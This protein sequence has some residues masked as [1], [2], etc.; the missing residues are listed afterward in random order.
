MNT[1]QSTEQ[2][3][4]AKNHQAPW[5]KLWLLNWNYMHWLMTSVI[6]TILCS[7]A[8]SLLLSI[9][10]EFL[11]SFWFNLGVSSSFIASSLA[12]TTVLFVGLLTGWLIYSAHLAFYAFKTANHDYQP[13]LE[14]WENHTPN[15]SELIDKLL[16]DQNFYDLSKF[17]QQQN[18]PQPIKAFL[19]N[20]Q[21]IQQIGQ[22]M[23]L[24]KRIWQIEKLDDKIKALSINILSEFSNSEHSKEHL[25]NIWNLCDMLLKKNQFT[26]DNVLKSLENS[27]QLKTYLPTLSKLY[28]HKDLLHKIIEEPKLMDYILA[29][30]E[31]FPGDDERI[32]YNIE[33]LYLYMVNRFDEV[34]VYEHY[35]ASSDSQVSKAI[36]QPMSYAWAKTFNEKPQ[37]F[38]KLWDNLLHHPNLK[39]LESCLN[40]ML[41]QGDKYHDITTNLDKALDFTQLFNRVSSVQSEDFKKLMAL[42]DSLTEFEDRE[43]FCDVLSDLAHGQVLKESLLIEIFKRDDWKAVANHLKLYI[44]KTWTEQSSFEETERNIL[45]LTLPPVDVSVPLIL[46]QDKSQEVESHLTPKDKNTSC[47]SMFKGC[48][49]AGSQTTS[50][51]AETPG[52]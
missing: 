14:L 50:P 34:D 40:F 12:I 27:Q 47:F 25:D 38:I 8:Y 28:V 41:E 9:Y 44:E 1:I 29:A 3:V 36:L 49:K 15:H 19:G 35:K 22:V 42:F 39:W 32:N 2:V 45:A 26:Q 13:L 7:E 52:I 17:L 16:S 43:L 51:I 23:N 24:L 21:N 6:S 4:L 10:P 33:V 46:L 5:V 37:Q 31:A 48:C 30:Q 20:Q 11:T 18:L